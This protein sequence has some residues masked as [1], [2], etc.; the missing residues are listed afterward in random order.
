[1]LNQDQAKRILQFLRDHQEDMVSRVVDYAKMETPS[2][3]SESQGPMFDRLAADFATIGFDCQ[4]FAG[5]QS[6][7]QML[8]VAKDE[9]EGAQRQLLLGH[10]DTVWPHRTLES[11]PVHVSDGRLFGPGVY[12][13]KGGLVQAMFALKAID[14]L[15]MSV[16]LSPV[17][18]INSD[19]EIG[20][21]ESVDRIQGLAKQVE[22]AFVLEPA[23]EPGGRI[24]TSRKG[25]GRF[26]ITVIGRAS[27]A[28]LAPEKGISAILESSHV[29]Q[30]LSALNDPRQGVTV[31]VGKISG[32]T[33][34]NVVAAETAMVV[35]VRVPTQA[36]ADRIEHAIRSL[37]PTLEGAELQISGQVGRPPMESTDRNQK[38]W[39]T[40]ASVAELL[41]LPI[42]AGAAGGGS[43]GNY[44]SL[45]TATLDGLGAVGDG[46][47]A[48]NEHLI[49]EKMPER[50]ALLACMLLS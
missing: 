3:D 24:K 21:A 5:D 19:E 32:G 27:H 6:G 25:V 12:D 33:Q 34:P 40:A 13:M 38:L 15:D 7:G 41:G 14:A 36:D 35:D 16:P 8:A 44:T 22:R 29:I 50:A 31:N 28:G 18:F 1:M 11:M 42:E 37:Q 17:F 10:C 2:S 20:S 49:I 46:A 4:R 47:H 45:H 9:P 23:L 30:S 48:N 26:T 43:D 39:K